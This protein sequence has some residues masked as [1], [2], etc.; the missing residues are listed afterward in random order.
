MEKINESKN[1]FFVKINTKLSQTHQE[2]KGGEGSNQ[3]NRN[4]KELHLTAQKYK[5][6][7]KTTTSNYIPKIVQPRRNGKVL[8]QVQLSKTELMRNRKDE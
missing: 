3:L 2:K 1:W 4:E 7:Q 8:R 6:S 5:R